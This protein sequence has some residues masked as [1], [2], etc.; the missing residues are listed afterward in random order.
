MSNYSY[1]LLKDSSTFTVNMLDTYLQLEQFDKPLKAQTHY[2]KIA[3]LEEIAE[4]LGIEYDK[5]IKKAELYILLAQRTAW[6]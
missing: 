6:L 4:R 2:K 5:K 3:E 1:C